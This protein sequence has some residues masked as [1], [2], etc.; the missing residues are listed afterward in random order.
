MRILGGYAYKGAPMPR[1]TVYVS[2]GLKARMD[3]L[4][5]RINW[6]EAAQAAF[7]RQISLATLPED[8]D[9]NDVIERVRESKVEFEL[10]QAGLGREHGREWA[11]KR[12]AYEDLKN[13][14]ALEFINRAGSYAAQFQRVYANG[15][16]SVDDFWNDG[17]S[18]YSPSDEY[19]EAYVEG[20]KDIWNE[21]ADKI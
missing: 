16:D 11:M 5:D 14:S 19:V 1:I 10:A 9:M 3:V 8:L 21:I 6:S 17:T 4:N 12:A 2:D 15:D 18:D 20:V 7:E 13:I